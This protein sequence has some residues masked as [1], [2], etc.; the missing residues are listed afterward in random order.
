MNDINSN[1]NNTL[2][3]LNESIIPKNPFVLFDMW[4][5]FYKQI[6]QTSEP[7]AMTLATIDNAGT[8]ATRIVLLKYYNEKGFTFFTNYQSNKARQ[9]VNSNKV[10]L[11]FYWPEIERQIRITGKTFKISSEESDKYFAKRPRGSKIGAWASPQS[12]IIPSE[13]FLNE[14]VKYFELKFADSDIPR[15]EF[16]GGY[17]V[18]PT[19]IEF[20]QSQKNRLHHRIIYNKQAD[21]WMSM[22]LAP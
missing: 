12:Q 22:R 10:S 14:K 19:S 13:H 5:T 9:L 20:W 16:W 18:K 1:I 11:L 8:P 3:H 4:F 21:K 17:I 6:S 7:D 2:P 15:P